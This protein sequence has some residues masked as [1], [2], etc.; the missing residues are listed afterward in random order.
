MTPSPRARARARARA[1]SHSRSRTRVRVRVRVRAPGPSPSPPPRSPRLLLLAL[2]LTLSA[3]SP[4]YVVRAGIEEA[5][6]LSRRRPI[7]RVIEDPTTSAETRR[8][9]ELVLQAR[10]FAQHAL[11]LDA[12]ESYTTYSYVDSDTLLMVV[13]GSRRDRF[14]AVTWWFPIV[15]HVPYKGYFD[16]EAAYRE[17]RRLEEA[18][19]DT[20]VRPSGAFS[21]LGWF[22]DPL[23]NTVLRYDD[24]GLVNTVIHE[25]LHNTIYVPSRISFNESFANFVGERGAIRFFC[26]RDGEES[27]RCELARASWADNLLYGEFLSSL[28]ADLEVVYAREDID[29]DTRMRLREEVFDRARATFVREVEPALRTNA[30][31]GFLRR[32]LNNA[33]LIGTRLYYDRLPLFEAVHERYGGDFVAALRAILA[34]ARADPGD[35][36]RAVE[37]LAGG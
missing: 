7:A 8:K 2:C 28:V 19:Y 11:D 17:A 3:C 36:W 25:L 4:L 1:R 12:G 6:I 10:D 15:G 35:P 13:S 37:R 22:N 23:L 20:Y 30:F 27:A 14:E 29:F 21:T 32:P 5:K 16:F 9:L 33:T 31:R 18:G 24:V 34:A 26:D